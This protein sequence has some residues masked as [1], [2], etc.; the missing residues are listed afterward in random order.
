QTP[1]NVGM[2]PPRRQWGRIEFVQKF[3]DESTASEY[4]DLESVEKAQV[5]IRSWV[6][7]EMGALETGSNLRGYWYCDSCGF[8]A[9][10]EGARPT[11]HQ[12][13]RTLAPCR[14]WPEMRSLGHTYQ[15]DITQISVPTF[16][17]TD[18]A[19]WRPAM[20]ALIEAASE[21]LEINRDDL[22]GTLSTQ[23]GIPTMVLFDTVPGGAGITRKVRESFP[24]V[25]EAAIRRVS[26]CGCGVDT[27]C[28][29]CLRSYSNQR[30]HRELRRDLALDL[31]LHMKQAV[32]AE[33]RG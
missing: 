15:T 32:D 31:L 28:Y 18:Y 21:A 20:Y 6:R 33:R 16:L 2:T 5:L 19:D 29:A 23:D 11:E 27:S 22:N 12:N 24:E 4:A 30:F 13:P 25:L 14:I 1:R 9:P 7:T 10:V 8:A 3:G 26:D 17:R